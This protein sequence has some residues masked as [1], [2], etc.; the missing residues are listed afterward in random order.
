MKKVLIAEDDPFILDI[1]ISKLTKSGFEVEKT[2]DG[3]SVVHI[4][5]ERKPDILLLDLLLPNK[6]GFEILEEIRSCPELVDLPVI[7][8]SNETGSDIEEKAAA[9]NATYFFKALTGTGELV[10]K[11]EEVLQ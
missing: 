1:T 5:L 8:F 10:A 9:F 3:N 11:I 4:L 6:H 7:V 2:A